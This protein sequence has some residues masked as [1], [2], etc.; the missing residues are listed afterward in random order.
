MPGLAIHGKAWMEDSRWIALG[1]YRQVFKTEENSVVT[2]KITATVKTIQKHSGRKKVGDTGR[3]AIRVPGQGLYP[4]RPHRHRNRRRWPP[5]RRQRNNQQEQRL[6]HRPRDN[7]SANIQWKHERGA[8]LE[9]S[10]RALAAQ[11]KRIRVW[12]VVTLPKPES[13][14]FSSAEVSSHRQIQQVQWHSATTVA[15]TCTNPQPAI[16]VVVRCSQVPRWGQTK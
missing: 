1:S 2:V 9:A 4:T 12:P 7:R 5:Q 11:G 8:E 3:L 6:H 14:S 16:R 15:L 13:R 10:D